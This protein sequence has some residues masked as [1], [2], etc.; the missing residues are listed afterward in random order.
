MFGA[1]LQEIVYHQLV[2]MGEQLVE[3]KPYQHPLYGEIEIGGVKKM[4]RRVPALFQL[5]ETCHRNAAFCLY[6]ADQLP[7][8]RVENVNVKKLETASTGWMSG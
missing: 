6:H 2:L 5:A 7:R 3:W 8:L 4:G 1:G